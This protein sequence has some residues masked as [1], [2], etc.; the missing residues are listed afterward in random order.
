MKTA[1]DPGAE[2]QEETRAQGEEFVKE[3]LTQRDG[4]DLGAKALYALDDDVWIETS[5]GDP[6]A[7]GLH[8]AHYSNRLY[9]RTQPAGRRFV[10][11]G[12]RIVLIT[13]DS[14]ALFVWRKFRESGQREPRGINCSIFRRERSTAAAS[15]MILRAEQFAWAKWPGE[16]L[17][18]YVA[19]WMVASPN[20]GYCF[21]VAGWQLY[22]V[23]PRG[24]HELQKLP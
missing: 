6:R 15:D 2:K 8:A 11:P 16:R 12:Q 10:G 21:K 4:A 23:T 1:L 20:P 5:D 13:P 14:G 24:L 17:Y 19:P 9:G 22:R 3:N 18:T 7:A